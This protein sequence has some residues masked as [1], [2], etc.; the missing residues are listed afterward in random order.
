MATPSASSF[1]DARDAA[2]RGRTEVT[3]AFGGDVHFAQRTLKLLDDP[4]TAIGPTSAILSA[5]DVAMVNL[6]TAVT[7]RGVAEPKQFRFRAP[8]T[9][10]TALTAAG[11][12]VTTMANNH[13]LDYGQ[14]GLA[15]TFAAIQETGHPVVGIGR[16]ASEAFAPWVKDVRGT[17]VAFLGLSQIRERAPQWSATAGRPGVASALDIPTATAAVQTARKLADVVV[18]YLHWGQEGEECPTDR[19]RALAAALAGAGADAIVSTHAHMMLGDGYLGRTYVQY[20][21]GNFVWWRDDAFSNDTGVLTL[22]V[23]GRD[24]TKAE[25]TPARISSTGQPVLATSAEAQRITAKYHKLRAC[26]GLSATP[27]P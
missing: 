6:E 2:A 1:T 18:V 10:F 3:L 22:T 8:K 26:A 4:A 27:T 7:E 19:M 15:D 11:V 13:A 17:K 14:S 20:G 16:T 9:A 25:L 5:A 21:L 24:V 12:D 23:K